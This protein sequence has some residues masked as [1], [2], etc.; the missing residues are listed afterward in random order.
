MPGCSGFVLTVPNLNLSYT[1]ICGIVEGNY[2]G[3]P[4]GFAGSGR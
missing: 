2:F 4:D 3:M 1:H